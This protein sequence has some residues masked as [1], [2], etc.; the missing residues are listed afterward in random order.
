[1]PKF[2]DVKCDCCGKFYQ[3]IKGRIKEAIKNGW[4]QYCSSKCY[5]KA[6][7]KSLNKNCITCGKKI[8]VRFTDYTRSQSKKFF[9]CK[10]CAA[11]H[12]NKNRKHSEETKIKISISLKKK[13][14]QKECIICK[15][16]FNVIP[17]KNHRIVCSKKCGQIYQFGSLSYT[18]EEV[19]DKIND[20]YSIGKNAPSSK[21][22]ES[23]LYSAVKKYF[24][25]W[26]KAMIELKIKPNTQWMS[27]KF[28]KCKD[29]HNADSISEMILDNWL[30]ENKLEHTRH[31]KYL[32]KRKLNC[33][34]YLTNYDIWIEYF[35]LKNEHKQYDLKIE[36]KRKIVK[37]LGL[38]LIEIF[39]EDLYPQ[40]NLENRI[41]SVIKRFQKQIKIEE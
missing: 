5:K 20:L 22:V 38:T 15:K 11:K 12:N 16:I 37:E 34:F 19:I 10:S 23:K 1:M 30:S 40:N 33:D 25:T 41:M 8:T 14:I 29:G 26:N 28:L 3:R 2:E 13:S 36:E 9:C 39:P 35:G 7:T 18:K 32:E 17:S 6:R 21:L 24:G 27:R 31:K 4:K